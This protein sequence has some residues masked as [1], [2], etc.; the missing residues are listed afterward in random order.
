MDYHGGL[1]LG[2][3]RRGLVFASEV[4]KQMNKDGILSGCTPKD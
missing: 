3:E 2:S 4:I 1:V